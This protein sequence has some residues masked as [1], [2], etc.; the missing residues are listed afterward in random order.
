M[1]DD[2]LSISSRVRFR[3]VGE[4]GVLVH[5]DSGRVV[6]VNGVG[7]FLVQQ[8]QQPRT[9]AELSRAIT[10]TFAVESTEAET[11]LSAY[12]DDLAAE[13]MLQAGAKG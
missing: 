4:E 2:T 3:A 6:V 12:L 8:L 13:E 10:D 9:R 7:L 11:D 5:L 1:T